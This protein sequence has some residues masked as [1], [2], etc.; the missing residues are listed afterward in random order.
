LRLVDI[1]CE[2]KFRTY[3]TEYV[4]R[5]YFPIDETLAICEKRGAT[6]ACAVLFKRKGQY[7]DSIKKYGDVLNELS[8]AYIIYTLYL[9]PHV[10]FNDPNTK[11]EHIIHFDSIILQMIKICEKYGSRV[12]DSEKEKLWLYALKCL[13]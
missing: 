4:A 12:A 3:I 6:E 11:N 10:P 2:K 5:I 8:Q 9:D 7:E 13:F 1:L